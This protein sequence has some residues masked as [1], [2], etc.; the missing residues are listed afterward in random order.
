MAAASE[1]GTLHPIEL[2]GDLRT[3]S[4]IGGK[5]WSSL[6]ADHGGSQALLFLHG[7][8]VHKKH[9]GLHPKEEVEE[10]PFL[11]LLCDECSRN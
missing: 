10:H 9:P 2:K 5:G 3:D 1:R 6:I 8:Q 7:A 4:T 11:H